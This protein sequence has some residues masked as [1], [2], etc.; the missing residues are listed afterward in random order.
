M[1]PGNQEN[2]ISLAIML[3]DHDKAM[4]QKP[5]SMNKLNLAPSIKNLI[6][7]VSS[8]RSRTGPL[9][10]DY[11]KEFPYPPTGNPPRVLALMNPPVGLLSDAPMFILLRGVGCVLCCMC[12]LRYKY[13]ER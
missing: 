3:R 9:L 12:C 2:M 5:H 7:L 13:N 11:W 4:R 10:L 6:H 8:C 1:D